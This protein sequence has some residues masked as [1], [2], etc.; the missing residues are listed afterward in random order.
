MLGLGSVSDARVSFVGRSA[1]HLRRFVG[2][3]KVLSCCSGRLLIWPCIVCPFWPLLYA[4][5]GFSR[6]A[7]EVQLVGRD[8][9]APGF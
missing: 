6:S 2:V 1:G 7:F 9:V 3:E 4:L 8:S 5:H